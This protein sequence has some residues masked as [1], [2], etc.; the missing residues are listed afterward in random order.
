MFPEELS[1]I[2]NVLTQN[3]WIFD[4]NL[5]FENRF[6]LNKILLVDQDWNWKWFF[7]SFSLSMAGRPVLLP[8]ND[9]QSLFIPVTYAL[10]TI[11]VIPIND[12]I[13]W[14]ILEMNVTEATLV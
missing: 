8:N 12:T 7:F 10:M 9:E 4:N 3:V 1:E 14:V 6:S 13:K 5:N 11:T 2:E